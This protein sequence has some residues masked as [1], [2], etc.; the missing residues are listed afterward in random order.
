MKHF[1]I[2]VS[3]ATLIAGAAFADRRCAVPMTDWQPR[4]KVAELAI[5]KGWTVRRIRI[6]DGCYQIIGTDAKGKKI[7]VKINPATLEIVQSG[8]EDD[9]GHRIP[10]DDDDD[11]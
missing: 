4:A 2:V 11:H 5:E 7:V 6:D 9:E 1:L 8:R 3:C 10:H